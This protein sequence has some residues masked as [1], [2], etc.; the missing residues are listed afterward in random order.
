MKGATPL[1]LIK[2]FN[3]VH[4]FIVNYMPGVLLGVARH[5]CTLWFELRPS[6]VWY[7]A[8]DCALLKIKPPRTITRTPHSVRSMAQ[9]KASEWRTWLT[10]HS[11]F[12]LDVF[13]LV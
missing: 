4:R 10:F 8:I 3:I 11:L 9:W 13:Y 2:K 1:L 12:V 7:T 5:M 6:A